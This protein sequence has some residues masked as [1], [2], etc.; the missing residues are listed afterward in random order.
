MSLGEALGIALYAIAGGL[1][2]TVYFGLLALML[3]RWG[4]EVKPLHLL[5]LFLVRFAGA[6]IVFWLIAQQGTV[7]VISA[8]AGFLLARFAVQRTLRQEA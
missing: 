6:A 3:R 5:G 1:A 2:G 7:P 4:S 8:L